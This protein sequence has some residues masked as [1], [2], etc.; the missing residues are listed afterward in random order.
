VVDRARAAASARA[1][2]AAQQS[3]AGPL[4]AVTSEDESVRKIRCEHIR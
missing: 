1:R 3:A 4:I 2:R